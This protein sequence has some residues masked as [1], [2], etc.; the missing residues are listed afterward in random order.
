[1]PPG[2]AAATT[3]SSVSLGAIG[4]S[5]MIVDGQR[6]HL[7]IAGTNT[8]S[9]YVLSY[10]GQLVSVIP[11]EVDISDMIVNGSTL[12]VADH[13]ANQIDS[14]NLQTFKDNG[15]VATG[16]TNLQTIAF[17]HGELWASL[18]S[19]QLG[20]TADTLDSIDLATGAIKSYSSYF[21]PGYPMISATPALPDDLF[22]TESGVL[23]G[24]IIKVSV[25]TG[26][27]TVIA[28]SS[29]T[30][31]PYVDL[32]STPTADGNTVVGE[33]YY[34][35]S[36]FDVNTMQYNGLSFG[37]VGEPWPAS[38]ST[39]KGL[40]AVAFQPAVLNYPNVLVY[41]LD[42]DTPLFS[43]TLNSAQLVA[44]SPDGSTLFVLDS[45]G[46]LWITGLPSLVDN[47]L[48]LTNVPADIT[49]DATS[50]SGAVITY[51]LPT[52]SDPD[53]ST[54]PSAVCTPS[55][56]STFPTGTTTVTCTVSDSDDSNSP[57]TAGFTVTVTGA[58]GQLA[59][60]HQTVQGPGPGRSLEDKVNQALTYLASSDV[61]DTCS[62]LTVFMNEVQAQSGKHVAPA[63]ADQLVA[64]ARRI[65]SVLAC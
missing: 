55:S 45:D 20:P 44:L 59:H 16:L 22:L 46:T 8:S 56:G 7:L 32:N 33:G 11:D 13:G 36:E 54:V 18:V 10:S 29:G 12:Y 1:M 61:P 15:P 37:A 21:Y 65:Q 48:A 49:T 34:D 6:S 62:S 9:I 26:V 43:E 28:T 63:T 24:E 17:A 53:D 40:I 38:W 14:V 60:L 50:P 39:E 5:E 31:L 47:D 51:P 4:P 19:P 64:D 25:A 35:A 52:V 30:Q 58:A 42:S 41:G 2:A 57:V 23:P 27:P 3:G